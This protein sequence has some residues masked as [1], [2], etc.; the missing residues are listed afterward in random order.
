MRDVVV[1]TVDHYTFLRRAIRLCVLSLTDRLTDQLTDRLVYLAVKTRTDAAW[2]AVLM[3]PV[4]ASYHQLLKQLHRL[5]T[6]SLYNE[7]RCSLEDF[8][9]RTDT[10]TL[11]PRHHSSSANMYQLNCCSQHFANISLS[12]SFPPFLSTSFLCSF[13][14][15]LFISASTL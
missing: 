13:F 1:S 12:V 6:S 2:W 3:R 9:I 4:D 10:V 5:S 11:V 7:L 8:C 14:T 15:V